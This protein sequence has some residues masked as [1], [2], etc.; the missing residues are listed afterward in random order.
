MTARRYL[1]VAAALGGVVLAGTVVAG[2]ASA[3]TDPKERSG[4]IGLT[5]REPAPADFAAAAREFAVPEP[6]LLAYSYALTRWQ[7]HNGTPSAQGGYGPMHLTAPDGVAP[8]GRGGDR[9]DAASRLRADPARNTLARAAALVGQPPARL[10]TDLTQNIRGGAALLADEAHRTGTRPATVAA[11]YP[12]VVRLSGASGAATLADD[13]F[14]TLRAGA[15]GAHLRLAAQ[16]DVATPRRAAAAADGAECPTDLACRFVPAAYAWNNTA[17]AND[18]G[19][20]DP[21]NR[22]A[23]GNQVRYIVI[24]DTEGSYDGTVQW[25]QN[26]AAYTSTHYV[27]RSSD[28]AVTQMVHTKDVAWHAGNWNINSE[29]I[30]IEH[31]AVAVDGAAWYTDAMYRSSA[32]LVRYLAQRY[33]IPLDRQHIVGHDD[34]ANDGRYA[35]SHWDPGPFWDW[36]RYFSLLHAPRPKVGS[37]LVTIAPSFASNRPP[38]RYCDSTGCRDL[39]AQPTNAVLLRTAP[40]DDAPLLTDALLGGGGTND[41]ADWSDKAVT[42]RRYAVAGRSGK[43]TA[44]W[45]AGQ[46]AWLHTADLCKVA[47]V[48]VRPKPGVQVPVFAAALPQPGEWPA[49]TPAG[50]PSTPPAM[51]A[52]YTISGDQRYQLADTQRAEYYYARFDAANVPLNHTIVVGAQSYYRISFNHRYLYV[53]TTDVTVG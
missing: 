25:F 35:G 30:G 43:W 26:P 36:D 53:R 16:P 34:V 13:V 48:T 5:A 20:Y 29:S 44:I 47:G 46:Q 15:A 24:H 50:Q 18:Y 38:L 8:S 9:P 52:L 37:Q 6:L 11:W 23:D 2:T 41:I 49:G 19:N 32:K 1:A 31:E 14:D 33:G 12:V 21:A 3:Q 7:D 10:R 4:A 42:G 51:K 17:D 45:Y 28:G 40:R 22:P 27:I 39:P